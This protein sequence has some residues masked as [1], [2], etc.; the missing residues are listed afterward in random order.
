M[1]H[2]MAAL[3]RVPV[4][5]VFDQLDVESVET[6]GRADVKRAFADLFDGA[7][8]GKRQKEPKVIRKISIGAGDGV[9]GGDVLS[10]KIGAVCG[11]DEFRLGLGGGGTGLKGCEGLGH[12]PFGAALDVDVVSLKNPIEV[13]LVGRASA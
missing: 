4:E 9:A 2:V 8:A 3:G 12:L 11:E 5:V 1:V 7:D 13:R 6:A 10:L